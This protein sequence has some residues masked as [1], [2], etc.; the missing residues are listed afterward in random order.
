MISDRGLPVLAVGL[1]GLLFGV[2]GGVFAADLLLDEGETVYSVPDAV[3]PVVPVDVRED[4]GGVLV[5]V[6]DDAPDPLID[7]AT[8][9]WPTEFD[10]TGA[11]AEQDSETADPPPAGPYPAIMR[12]LDGCAE[13]SAP[14]CPLGFGGTI[15][16]IMHPLE[17][18]VLPEATTA[19]I[20]ELRCSPGWPTP[21]AVP[22]ALLTNR[23]LDL[24][25]V[26]LLNP[27]GTIVDD[28]HVNLTS[29]TSERS[30]YDQRLK[31][32]TPTAATVR[33]GL[34]HCLLFELDRRLVP[35]PERTGS[36]IV[37]VDATAGDDS[38]F[39]EV[40]FNGER[41]ALRPPI[42]LIPINE[43]Q[44]M[45]TVPLIYGDAPAVWT[46]DSEQPT[47]PS[48]PLACAL[49]T[50]QPG[51]EAAGMTPTSQEIDP[52]IRQSP[53]YPWDPTYTHVT[54]WELNLKNSSDYTLCVQW[55]HEQVTEQWAL[56]TPDGRHLEVVAGT[57]SHEYGIEA[58]DL[59]VRFVGV[60]DCVEG[61]FSHGDFPH[62]DLTGSGDYDGAF[63]DVIC[64]SDG[65]FGQWFRLE[66]RYTVDTR[67]DLEGTW[68]IATPHASAWCDIDS[69]DG[70]CVGTLEWRNQNTLCG[71]QDVF[72][73][74]EF[75]RV[76]PDGTIKVDPSHDCRPLK[77]SLEVLVRSSA[78]ADNQRPSP[79]DWGFELVDSRK[80]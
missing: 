14:G 21:T 43:S 45:L 79:L 68:P 12:W 23:P 32:G 75:P 24:V 77:F 57:L 49:P 67:H 65:S 73:D 28:G 16:A 5:Q 63:G 59:E 62:V 51:T 41:Q 36:F 7:G 27:D 48:G 31:D 54:V 76:Q 47:S 13:V 18:Q 30:L 34:H 37:E 78:S 10:E 52:A 58:G 50:A 19:V 42:H 2:V 64:E 20:P 6:G 53:D 25:H 80:S 56:E 74:F 1:L 8:E 60:S 29:P 66:A 38:L 17:I 11:P 35:S 39:L 33:S 46:Y 71:G 69:E 26:R 72:L 22:L 44:G 40:P 70:G 55:P 15:E 61:E 4:P 3:F 9:V